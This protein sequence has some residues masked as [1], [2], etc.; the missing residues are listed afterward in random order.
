MLQQIRSSILD[1]YINNALIKGRVSSNG[2]RVSDAMLIESIRSEESIIPRG[3]D[4]DVT[5]LKGYQEVR[6][7]ASRAPNLIHVYF[8]HLVPI[9]GV[10]FSRDSIFVKDTSRLNYARGGVDEPIPRVT[11]HEIGHA[12]GLAHRQDTINLLASGTTGWSLNDEEVAKARAWAA[13][14]A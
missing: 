11:S 9:T 12:M 1:A 3:F 7:R 13:T 14:S 8:I 6:P 2:Y 4:V 10:Y 5:R